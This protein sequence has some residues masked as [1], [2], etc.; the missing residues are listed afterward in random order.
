MSD[1]ERIKNE[2]LIA[3]CPHLLG[4]LRDAAGPAALEARKKELILIRRERPANDDL[5]MEAEWEFQPKHL[6]VSWNLFRRRYLEHGPP[7]Y[8]GIDS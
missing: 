5:R 7:G 1:E 4:K 6:G 8:F 3:A 2:K